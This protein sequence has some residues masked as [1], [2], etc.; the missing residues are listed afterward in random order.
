MTTLAQ[1]QV[2]VSRDLRDTDNKTFSLA[3]VTD[4]I[5]AGITEISLI[6]PR[7]FQED[8][9]GVASQSEYQFDTTGT[10]P[11]I[12]PVVVE[13]WTTS[14]VRFYERIPFGGEGLENST[15]GGWKWWNGTLSIPYAFA[16]KIDANYTIR[17]WGY[18]PYTQLANSSDTTDLDGG[19]IDAVREYAVAYGFQR[20]LSERALFDQWQ[21]QANNTDVSAASLL[22]IASTWDAKWNRRRRQLG[23]MRELS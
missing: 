15:E 5:N 10:D 19:K 12:R 20:L 13:V 11:R 17:V 7:Q 9:D 4:L 1:L 8:L 18:A 14:P 23:T 2:M 21:K 6:S 3:E 16:A 22:G